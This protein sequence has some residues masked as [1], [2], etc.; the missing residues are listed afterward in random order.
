MS[1]PPGPL[2]LLPTQTA[3]PEIL[4]LQAQKDKNGALTMLRGPI[5]MLE[6]QAEVLKRLGAALVPMQKDDTPRTGE[7]TLT[8]GLLNKG[9]SDG[10]VSNRATLKFKGSELWMIVADSWTTVKAHSFQELV[11]KAGGDDD[12][13]KSMKAWHEA[14]T[15]NKPFDVELTL[16]SNADMPRATYKATISKQ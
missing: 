16:N 2:S 14:I 11:V 13:G 9:D 4:V 1:S 5:V 3:Q 8:I 10:V 7:M 6:R 12:A 15:A